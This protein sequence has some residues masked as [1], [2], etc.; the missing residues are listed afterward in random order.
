MCAD[1]VV[2]SFQPPQR[3]L[4]GPGPSDVHPRVLAAMARPTIGHLDPE[5]VRMMDELKELLRYAFQTQ[6]D[7][8]FAMSGPGF[9]RHGGL[10]CQPPR[11]R[12]TR[13]RL[14]QRRVRRPHGR[15]RRALR[16]HA[17]RGRRRVGAPVSARQACGRPESEPGGRIVAFVQAETSTGA[18]TDPEPLVA[19]AH[20][21]DCIVIVER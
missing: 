15:E 8:T 3:T 2:G 11:G 14:P 6:N 17:G 21:H 13:N 10:L 7:V 9:G 5:F 18:L 4:M 12:A 19:L 1:G 20:E 16:R